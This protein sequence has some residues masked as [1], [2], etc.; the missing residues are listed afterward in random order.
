MTG[1]PNRGPR[2][3]RREEERDE[4]DERVIDITRVAKVVK[5]GRHFAF[6]TVVV[7]GDNKGRVGV[8]VGKSRGV[9]DSI[10]KGSEHA[11]K[12]MRDIALEG[13]TIPHEVVG[14]Y[15]GAEVLLRPASPGTGVI[16][17]GSVRAVLEA[18]GIH[19]ILTKSR[20]SSNTLNVAFA[21]LDALLQLKQIDE[22]AAMRGKRPEEIQPFWRRRRQET[23]A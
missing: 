8:G 4:L 7:V 19:D 21:T 16:A 23:Q 3:D 2:R 10:R 6:R 5:G 12:A 22:L 20:G 14:R 9:P 11:R 1:K 18:V 13:T 15:G 17:A